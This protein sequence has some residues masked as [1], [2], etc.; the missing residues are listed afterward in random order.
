MPEL[1]KETTGIDEEDQDLDEEDEFGPRFK[2]ILDSPEPE[3]VKISKKNCCTVELLLNESNSDN[4]MEHAK[5]I[6]YFVA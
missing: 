6:Q 2:V 3:G 5:M 1:E 4:A